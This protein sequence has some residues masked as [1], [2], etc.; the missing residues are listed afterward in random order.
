MWPRS[1]EAGLHCGAG[2]RL[3]VT[4][5][6][7]FI[8]FSAL[9]SSEDFFQVSLTSSAIISHLKQKAQ[10]VQHEHLNTEKIIRP[11]QLTC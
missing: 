1:G 3:N 9:V 5:N 2:A 10:R 4:T 6:L 8:S 7:A 11:T